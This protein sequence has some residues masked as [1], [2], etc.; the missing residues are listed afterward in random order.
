MRLILYSLLIM[1]F[2]SFLQIPQTPKFIRDDIDTESYWISVFEMIHNFFADSPMSVRL[3]SLKQGILG[4]LSVYRE[5]PRI[6]SAL[7][8]GALFSFSTIW[9]RRSQ[10]VDQFVWEVLVVFLLGNTIALVFLLSFSK[11]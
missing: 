1:H 7:L 4:E 5:D 8:L 9:L 3:K 10:R 6:A 2:M 11:V